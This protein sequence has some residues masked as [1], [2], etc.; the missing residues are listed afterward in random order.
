MVERNLVG[1]PSFIAGH[2]RDIPAVDFFQESDKV[3][4][5]GFQK[6]NEVFNAAISTMSAALC[7]GLI[8]FS[9]DLISVGIAGAAATMAKLRAQA[10]LYTTD[11]KHRDYPVTRPRGKYDLVEAALI[12]VAVAHSIA[13]GAF[14]G[15]NREYVLN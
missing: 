5:L 10:S 12:N 13:R 3:A 2:I 7:R 9:R 14:A 11:I 1:V 6:T 8:S 15:F 4:D